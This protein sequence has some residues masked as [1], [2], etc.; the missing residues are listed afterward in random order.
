MRLER[1][2]FTAITGTIGSG[3]TTLLK[4]LIGLLPLQA[5]EIYWNAQKVTHPHQFFVPPG[6]PIPRKFLSFLA[7]RCEI[8]LPWG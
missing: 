4:A 5:G 7:A 1:G 6:A 3:K 8:T 2:S